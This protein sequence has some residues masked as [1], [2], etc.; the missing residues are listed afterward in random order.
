M[1][2]VYKTTVYDR[3]EMQRWVKYRFEIACM[4]LCSLWIAR[5]LLIVCSFANYKIQHVVHKSPDML[6]KFKPDFYWNRFIAT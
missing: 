3:L 1:T 5:S 6:T 4:P 2:R